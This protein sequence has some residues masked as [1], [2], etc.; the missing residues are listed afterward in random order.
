MGGHTSKNMKVTQISLFFFLEKK[1]KQ[2]CVGRDRGVNL[3]EVVDVAKS[4]EN[5]CRKFSKNK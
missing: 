5:T 1:I 4:Y 2:S 3:R